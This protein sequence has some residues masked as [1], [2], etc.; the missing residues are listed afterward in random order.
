MKTPFSLSLAVSLS[1]G[2]LL[3]V[4]CD[5]P[6][7]DG[8][9]QAQALASVKAYISGE[10]QGLH[11][12]SVA[13]QTAAP[14][15]DADGWNIND[16]TAAVLAMQDEW[17]NARAGYER[18]EG[19]IAVL[20]PDLDAATDERYDG[21]IAEAADDNLF[22]GD[23]VTG[24]HGIERILWSDEIPAS[25]VTFE[26][27]LGPN[28]SP[29]AFPATETEATD[30]KTKLTG[31]LVVD[32][33]TMVDD[34]EP[35]N[36]AIETAYRGVLGSMEE[37]FEK[38]SLAG[39]GEDESRYSQH[40]LADMRFNLEGGRAIFA[41][42]KPAFEEKG[43]DGLALFDDIDG[44][45]DRAEAKLVDI[46]GDAIPAVPATWNPDAPSED[47]KA[48]PYGQLFLFFENETDF[49]NA[50]SFVSLFGDGADLLEI[51]QLAD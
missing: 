32:T 28:Y 43:D 27:G 7:L 1:A 51:P 16:D 6:D 19:A 4:G 25:V 42:F 14:A 47:D 37:Q 10:L 36:L 41:A 20:F 13:L 29:A 18:V 15:P 39:T 3:A 35:I 21:F 40:T 12:A 45:F 50:E 8:D 17:R 24:V 48:T 2:V 5:N 38:V 34:F 22:D 26:E 33:Q 49:D 44:A 46:G 11:D 9:P 23:G 31:R 30:F